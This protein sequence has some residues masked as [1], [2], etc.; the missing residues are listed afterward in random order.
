MKKIV[1]CLSY[2][3]ADHPGEKNSGISATIPDQSLTVKQILERFAMGLGYGNLKVQVYDE[4][5]IDFD[6][7]L[8]D[9]RRMD[10]A[11]AEDFKADVQSLE[12]RLEKSRKR[13]QKEDEDKAAAL[14]TSDKPK[15]DSSGTTTTEGDSKPS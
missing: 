3:P 9:L 1:S 15:T 13:K 11:E 10:L 14:S 12:K 7:Q 8:P 2:D 6:D 5:D 4:D